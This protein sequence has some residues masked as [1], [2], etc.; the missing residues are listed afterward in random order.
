MCSNKAMITS[1]GTLL[2]PILHIPQVL[3]VHKFYTSRN[4]SEIVECDVTY[5]GKVLK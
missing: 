2:G 5:L 3:Y 1:A 4:M